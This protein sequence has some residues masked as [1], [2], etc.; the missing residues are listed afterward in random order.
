M[1]DL[2]VIDQFDS[3][4]AEVEI[5]GRPY[6]L[7]KDGQMYR[8]LSRICPH[9]GGEVMVEDAKLYCPYHYWSFD[10]ATGC[11]I[12]PPTARLDAYNVSVEG[13]RFVAQTEAAEQT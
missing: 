12:F 9:A 7:V 4:P 5:E 6:F 8:L 1:T 3:F 11:G 13:G 10:A 2:G